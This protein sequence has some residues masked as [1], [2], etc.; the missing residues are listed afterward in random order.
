MF[1]VS[2]VMVNLLG[3]RKEPYG[4]L[5]PAMAQK[6]CKGAKSMMGD[7]CAA[8]KH[9]DEDSQGYLEL[10][11]YPYCYE[12]WFLALSEA[13]GCRQLEVRGRNISSFD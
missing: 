1:W 7:I 6:G 11:K 12:E 10:S 9:E 13:Y 8:M 3:H 5:L 2:T 4:A